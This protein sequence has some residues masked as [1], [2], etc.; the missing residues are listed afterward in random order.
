MSPCA[1]PQC[2][3]KR[4]VTNDNFRVFCGEASGPKSVSVLLLLFVCLVLLLLFFVCFCLFCCCCC[5][6]CGLLSFSFFFCVCA[7]VRVCVRVRVC[8]SV[9]QFSL[10]LTENSCRFT[11]VMLHTPQEQRYILIPIGACNIFMCPNSGTYC[12]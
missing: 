3:E 4:P 10:S 2:S 6:G 1:S 9:C 7:C 12:S 5:Y 11:W 8:V